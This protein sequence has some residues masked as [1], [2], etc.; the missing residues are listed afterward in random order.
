MR[1][2]T[3]FFSWQN[4]EKEAK[5]IINK[6]LR[7][8][9][10]DLASKDI[11]IEIDQDTRNRVGVQKIDVEILEKISKSD[12]F[13]ADITPVIT[14]KSKTKTGLDRHMP[15]SNVMYEFG[16]A[17]GVIG[18]SRTILFA[19]MKRGQH[20]ELMPFDIKTFTITEFKNENDLKG[21]AKWIENICNQVDL[22]HSAVTA[23]YDA[24]ISFIEENKPVN[25]IVVK[26]TFKAYMN[27]KEKPKV[28]NTELTD[29]EKN[30][31]IFGGSALAM[32]SYLS[33]LQQV[34]PA[35]VKPITKHIYRSYA[36][37]SLAIVNKGNALEN[38]LLQIFP[39]T[40]GVKF[41]RHQEDT[42]F[43]MQ[44]I[45][46]PDK[47]IIKENSIRYS[48]NVLNPNNA[49]EL[50]EAF[51][52]VPHG[53]TEAKLKWHIST[54]SGNFEGELNIHVE[55]EYHYETSYNNERAEGEVWYDEYVD[56]E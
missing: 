56:N 22:S 19:R 50:C 14:K 39:E 6:V 3:L 13:L 54:K 24:Y 36:P 48:Y 21:L 10:K 1:K 40:E 38:V 33:R 31:M 47:V 37:F 29:E 49:Y 20:I 2:Y 34:T 42:L 7:I 12:I 28:E 45:L 46:S 17:S 27:C 4:E 25:S 15:N 5:R 52:Y 55:P 30:R 35:I 43:A 53:I 11:E 9:K 23:Q 51:V 41:R 18:P 16:F 26:P 44:A 8:A 32:A